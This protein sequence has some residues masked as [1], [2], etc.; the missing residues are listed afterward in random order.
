MASL[1]AQVQDITGSS[2]ANVTDYLNRGANFVSASLPR[3]LL[4]SF[5]EETSFASSKVTIASW[6]SDSGNAQLTSS[7]H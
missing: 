4:W 5:T 3:H 6:A 2:N 1:L 7:S